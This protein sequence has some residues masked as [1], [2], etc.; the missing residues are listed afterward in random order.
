MKKYIILSTNDNVDYLHFTPLTC[1]AWR[2]FG[3]DPIIFYH[4]TKHN[5][6]LNALVCDASLPANFW[7]LESIDN[8]RS[9]T[10][11][12][13]SRLY[14]ACVA[15][16]Y[17]MTGDIDMLPLSD[18]WKPDLNKVTVYGHDLT[19]YTDYPICY[20]GAPTLLWFR[21]M[22]IDPSGVQDFNAYIKRDLD[23]L[24]QAKNPDF[25]TYWSTD[26]NHVTAR[27]KE[28]GTGHIDFINRGQYANGYARGRVDRG[29]WRLNH[30]EFIDCHMLRP[31]WN[32]ESNTVR[33]IELLN[34]LWPSEDFTWY[35]DFL[36]EF[37]RLAI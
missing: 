36:K 30:D 11:T 2:K 9:D 14:G 3:W 31:L 22:K 21:F 20:I 17:I 26:Q 7:P 27:L 4:S 25:Y 10:I 23:S 19:G 29:D 8:Y 32:N 12:Q 33:T 37:K 35:T 28:Y 18:Y 16:G 34:K 1:W 24:P 15:D 5:T 6:D 13:I